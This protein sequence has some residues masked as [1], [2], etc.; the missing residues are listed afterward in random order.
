MLDKNLGYWVLGISSKKRK[1]MN[2]RFQTW[3]QISG[4][5]SLREESLRDVGDP[6]ASEASSLHGLRR[7]H[8]GSHLSARTRLCRHSLHR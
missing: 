4:L 7:Q 6:L 5:W 8:F 2:C 3:F 1:F